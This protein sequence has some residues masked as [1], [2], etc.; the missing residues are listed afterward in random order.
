MPIQLTSRPIIPG[1]YT[2]G[3]ETTTAIR[4]V[5]MTK[6]GVFNI[7]VNGLIPSTLHYLFFERDRVSASNFKPVNGK[8]GDPIYTDQNGQ[9]SFTFYY[10]SPFVAASTED[11]Y[12]EY[13]QRLGGDK[14]LVLASSP[15]SVTTLPDN[16]IN[17]FNSV[18][19]RNIYFKTSKAS[20]LPISTEY[21]V[22][23]PPAP[24]VETAVNLGSVGYYD[25][26]GQID[27]T[28]AG[29]GSG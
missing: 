27:S 25:A 23:Y 18:A 15:S 3:S 14:Q 11:I 10:N 21:L 6:Q 24:V 17:A 5:Y 16:F 9:A 13:A 19:V 22:F 29:S 12:T 1:G 26:G 28:N 2:I 20:E 8:I 4:Y 7:T